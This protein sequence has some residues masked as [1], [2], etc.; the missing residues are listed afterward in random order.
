M[1]ICVPRT[2]DKNEQLIIVRLGLLPDLYKQRIYFCIFTTK[3]LL[4][5]FSTLLNIFSSF[6]Q[7]KTENS[8]VAHTQK[9]SAI[10]PGH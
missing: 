10:T 2:A 9:A 3:T 5:I 6:S 1:Q 8:L 4:S 7:N